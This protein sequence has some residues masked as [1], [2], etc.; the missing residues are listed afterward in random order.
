MADGCTCPRRIE[1]HPLL[2]WREQVGLPPPEPAPLTGA[3]WLAS[4]DARLGRCLISR[5]IATA[6]RKIPHHGY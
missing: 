1:N 5:S 4:E 3:E 6:R 2:E